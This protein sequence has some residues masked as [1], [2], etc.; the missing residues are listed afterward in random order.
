MEEL[1]AGYE[2]MTLPE[3]GREP[4]FTANN[5]LAWCRNL[6]SFINYVRGNLVVQAVSDVYHRDISLRSPKARQAG[7]RG[8]SSYWASLAPTFTATRGITIAEPISTILPSRVA[9]DKAKE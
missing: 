4:F 3:N 5:R 9:R 2:V 6:D 1:S 7:W 8:K